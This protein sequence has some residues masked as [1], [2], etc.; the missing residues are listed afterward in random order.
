[1]SRMCHCTIGPFDYGRL[2]M[3]YGYIQHTSAAGLRALSSYSR[4]PNINCKSDQDMP[5][6]R[7]AKFL[8]RGGKSAKDKSYLEYQETADEIEKAKTREAAEAW[9]RGEDG[10]TFKITGHEGDTP[11]SSAFPEASTKSASDNSVI[12]SADSRSRRATESKKEKP[13]STIGT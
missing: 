11:S 5:F 9:E 10:G 2:C 4:E 6:Q 7:L 12:Q 8:A 13:S 1:M 3:I